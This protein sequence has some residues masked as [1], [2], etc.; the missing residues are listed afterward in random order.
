MYRADAR[1]TAVGLTQ[2][3]YVRR[4][5]MIVGRSMPARLDPH[6]GKVRNQ[7]QLTS[8]LLVFHVCH[9]RA[10]R[11]RVSSHSAI[12]TVV[13][14][15]G[16]LPVDVIQAYTL[17]PLTHPGWSVPLCHTFSMASRLY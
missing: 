17:P 9:V 15:G 4:L 5:V 10:L 6:V 11:A 1:I 8:F 12:H 16:R 7:K 3:V 2:S 13:Q 14:S